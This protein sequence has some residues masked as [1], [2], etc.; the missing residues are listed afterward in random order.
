MSEDLILVYEF[1]LLLL[2]HLLFFKIIKVGLLASNTAGFTSLTDQKEPPKV[3]K[4]VKTFFLLVVE[5]PP[6]S[7]TA[8]TITEATTPNIGDYKHEYK[9]L[10][11]Q[12]QQLKYDRHYANI[13]V[14]VIKPG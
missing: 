10:S 5:G 2:F 14:W 12:K 1:V 4:L 9:C 11:G 13:N 7:A 3:E 8:K 6:T